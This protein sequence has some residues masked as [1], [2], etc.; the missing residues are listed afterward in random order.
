MKKV[1][2]PKVEVIKKCS[3][4]III[5]IQTLRSY[6]KINFPNEQI[7]E[8]GVTDFVFIYTKF[9]EIKKICK[10]QYPFCIS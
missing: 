6:M 1:G 4:I 10:S 8:Q 5:V 3:F 7:F 2:T 9:I